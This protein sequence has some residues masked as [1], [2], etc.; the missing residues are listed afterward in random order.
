MGKLSGVAG[1]LWTGTDK[2]PNIT[3]YDL[4]VNSNQ[5]NVSDHDSGRWG[6]KINTTAQWTA[7]MT[8]WYNEGNTIQAAIL[9]A[10]VSGASLPF[11]FRPNGTGTGKSK[12][13]GN[14]VIG[15]IKYGAPQ[16]AGQPFS[17]DIAG[18][19]AL[20]SGVQS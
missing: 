13:A 20:T 14:G 8:G 1:E 11:E 15:N 3:N 5:A 12:F 10:A 18:Q 9:A 2:V 17:F 19:G 4:T 7:S 6:E 16:D